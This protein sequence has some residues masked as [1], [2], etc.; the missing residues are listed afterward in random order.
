MRDG[1]PILLVLR[2]RRLGGLLTAVPALRALAD[3]YPTHQ[4]ILATE[5]PL[6]EFALHAGLADRVLPCR[7]F[8]PLAW[9]TFRPAIAVDLQGRGPLSQR[10]LLETRPARLITFSH[11]LVHQS[12]HG[13]AWREDEHE[14]RRWCRLLDESGIAACSSALDVALPPR[15][16]PAEAIGATILHPGASSAARRWPADRWA[17]VAADERA[18][19]RVVLI[20]GS[21]SER[22]LAFEIARRA[23]IAAAHVWAGRTS[24]VMLA[25]LLARAGRVVCGDTGVAHL[26]TAL[27]VPSVL[28]FGPTPPSEAGPP[29]YRAWHRLLWYGKTGDRHGYRVDPG[30]LAISV[31]DVQAALRELPAATSV[32]MFVRVPRPDVAPLPAAGA[33]AGR[34]LR[35]R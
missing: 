4:R 8:A 3:A 23:G 13:P 14:V 2:A 21:I 30:L 25:A 29:A 20:T 9:D 32:P 18:A 31:G 28:L 7:P 12:W 27:R 35:R 24:V 6:A 17:A 26:A 22:T 33:A 19:G 11:P 34:F 10:V 5:L 1:R 16:I 15:P